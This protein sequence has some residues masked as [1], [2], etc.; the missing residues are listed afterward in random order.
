MANE[1]NGKDLEKSVR[2]LQNVSTSIVMRGLDD[3][4][5]LAKHTSAE[6]FVQ[7]RNVSTTL[8][9]PLGEFSVASLF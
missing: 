6:F 3:L 1:R 2:V 4:T 8:R 5:F 7:K 9:H